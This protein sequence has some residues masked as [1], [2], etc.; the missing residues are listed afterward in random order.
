MDP[1]ERVGLAE[2]F[3]K[4]HAPGA[5]GTVVITSNHP[6]YFPFMTSARDGKAREKVWRAYRQRAHP[7][8]PP[9]LEQLIA[10]RHELATLLGYGHHHEVPQDGARAR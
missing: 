5:N 4:D 7:K 9:V 1:K 3:I 10:K 2:D 8:N 6:G